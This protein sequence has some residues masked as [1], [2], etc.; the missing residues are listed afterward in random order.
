MNAQ[1]RQKYIV[2]KFLLVDFE[3][4]FTLERLHIILQSNTAQRCAQSIKLSAG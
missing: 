1:H 3:A 4:D 2:M